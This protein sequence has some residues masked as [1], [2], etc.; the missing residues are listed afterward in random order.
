MPG[1]AHETGSS[2]EQLKIDDAGDTRA[3]SEAKPMTAEAKSRQKSDIDAAGAA[4]MD[5]LIGRQVG[6]RFTITGRIARGGMACVYRA[7]QAQLNRL[8]AIKVLRSSV[9]KDEASAADFRRRFLQEAEILSRLQHPNLVTLLDYGQIGEL[10]G[11]HYYIAMEYLQGETLARRFRSVGRLGV[12]QSIRIARQVGRGLREAHRQGFVHRDLKPSNI[13]LVPEDDESD[14]VK[15]ID[16]GIG[17]VVHARAMGPADAEE[18]ER[19]RVGL[20]LGSPRYMAPEQIR[21]ELVEPRTDLYGLGII[22]FQ[23]LTGH[24]PFEQK[25]EVETMLAHCSM[26]APPLDAYVEEPVGSLSDLVADLLQKRAEDRPTIHEFLARLANAESELFDSVGLAGPTLFGKRPSSPP[27]AG[28]GSIPPP[29][30]PPRPARSP[31][32]EAEALGDFLPAFKSEPP[33]VVTT[34]SLAASLA[35]TAPPVG[36]VAPSTSPAPRTKAWGL[37]PLALLGALL[38]LGLRREPAEAVAPPVP[39]SS[40]VSGAAF[41]LTLDSVPSHAVVREEGTVLGQTPLRLSIPRTTV[42]AQAR[43]FTLEREGFVPYTHEQADSVADTAALASLTPVPSA[44]T[45]P[46]LRRLR[47][48]DA[49]RPAP[50]VEK[51]PAPTRTADRLDI[52][53][54]R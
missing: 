5:A 52:N 36:L 49:A 45:D 15:L 20:L 1:D 39:A 23:A 7:T 35:P 24:V 19:T 22:L 31:R 37:L 9:V 33:T 4:E 40:T 18:E 54:A 16:F 46:A 2:P 11:D 32:F 21:G 6:G 50:S 53:L 30:P 8:V 29:P 47:K 28:F 41:V 26:P 34:G 13:M 42:S 48:R 14:I 25:S 43:R 10:P 27:R 44:T 38:W 12:A 3:A 51:P 17:K